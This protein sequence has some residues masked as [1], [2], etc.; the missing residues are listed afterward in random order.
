MDNDM[1]V[2]STDRRYPGLPSRLNVGVA[3]GFDF[4]RDESVSTAHFQ[5]ANRTFGASF[6]DRFIMTLRRS[7]R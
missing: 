1:V 5:Q 7:Y 4:D 6:S 2:K 3:L